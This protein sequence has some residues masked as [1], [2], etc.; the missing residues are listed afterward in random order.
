M[1]VAPGLV[2][3]GGALAYSAMVGYGDVT[4]NVT[5]LVVGLAAVIAGALGRAPHLVPIG[6]TL[7]GWGLAVLA[8]R[9]GPLPD[10]REAP[11]F[12]IG[13]GAGLVAG[14]LLTSRTHTPLGGAAITVLV[15][16]VALYFATDLRVLIEWPTWTGLLL[17]W[18]AWETY[19]SIASKAPV[20][21]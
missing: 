9:E 1:K 17:L 5:P 15:A 7:V 12:V 2:L 3:A 8:V 6:T 13:L 16:G 4:F 10:E 21:T 18:A 11:A 19:R 14:R 20:P